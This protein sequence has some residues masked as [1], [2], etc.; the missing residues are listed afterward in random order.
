[1]ALSPSLL[2]I[3]VLAVLVFA[4]GIFTFRTFLGMITV[5]LFAQCQMV[6]QRAGEAGKGLLVAQRARE[7]FQVRARLGFDGGAPQID[8][9][10]Q[11]SRRLLA[12]QLLAHHQ[13]QHIGQRGFVARRAPCQAAI[14]QAL[15]QPGRQIGGHA[16]MAMAPIAFTR[17]CSA[18][19]K[20]AAPPARRAGTVVDFLV[21]IGLA[22]GIGVA[23][24]AHQRHILGGRLRAARA[25]GLQAL[26][27]GRLA[28]EID[29]Q[30]R[31]GRQRRTATERPL[32]RFGGG[33]RLG[34][35]STLFNWIR[36]KRP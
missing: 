20:A 30:L 16:F 17:A 4:F 14:E 33:F 6:Q 25:G 23:D 15:F 5:G 13:A 12:G 7:L 8:R 36:L 1:V 22:Q 21:V 31:L 32:E 28:G 3:L 2:G 10:G 26:Q 19:S 18:A 11:R 9:R 35:Y 34:H 29:F 24:A 27:R